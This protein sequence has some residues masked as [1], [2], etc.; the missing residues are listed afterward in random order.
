MIKSIQYF[1]EADQSH[2]LVALD[3]K[4]AFQNVSRRSM[5]HSLRQHDHDLATVFS[6]WYT[7]STTHRMHYDGSYAHIDQGCPLSP[8]GFA[9]AVDPIS[10]YIL[11]QI[12]LTLDNGAKLWAYLDDWYIWIKPQHIPAAKE[13]VANATLTI[14]LELQPT[15]IQIWTASF[16]SP[17]PLD[18]LDKAKPTLKCLGAH[19]RIAGDSE[20]SPVEL[21][22][23]PSM[24]TATMRYRSISAILRDLN[25]AG[26]KMQTVIDLITMYVGAASQHELRTTFVPYEEAANFDNEIEAH[27]SKL[28]GR[29]VASPLFHLPLRMGGLGVGSAVQRHAAAPWTAWQTVIPTLMAATDSTDTDSLLAA[30]PI[31]RGQLLQLQS[32]L[33]QQMN[34]PALLL[35]PL[36]AALRTHGIQ[37]TLVGAIQRHAHKQIMDSY[38]DNPIQRAILISQTAKNTGAHLQQPNREAYEA[39][40]R[41]FQVSMARRLML[42]HPAAAHATDIAPT[43]PNV[44][45]A[46]RVCTCRIDAHQLHCIVCKSGGGV[47]QRHS[48]LARC[49][50]DLV[51]THTGAK[52]QIE[53]TI[54]GLPR[55]LRPRAQPERARMDIVFHLHGQIYYIDTAV[56]TPFSANAGLIA[57][58]S[59]RPSYMAKREEKKKFDRTPRINLVPFILET[60]GRPGLPCTKVHQTPIQR[61]GPPCNSHTRRVG[62]H[63]NHTP[64]LHLQATTP[65]GHHVTA[66]PTVSSPS[67]HH[68]AYTPPPSSP[69]DPRHLSLPQPTCISPR[70]PSPLFSC[71]GHFA[72]QPCSALA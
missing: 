62:C 59:T 47:D 51:T 25:Q 13:L 67:H 64:R 40:D 35:K 44:S 48:A 49:L 55:E 22:G 33:A 7:G 3:L 53:Q 66:L 2:V 11:T 61:H 12:Q 34:T 65:G 5:L 10:R 28:A 41:C 1:A 42:A 68:P 52:V 32:T 15:K 23:R 21:G 50:A 37:K 19:L 26:L 17:I 72:T 63:P 6:R 38:V 70:S 30:T 31:L 4:A 24:N 58:A 16:T 9:A 39:D 27:W 54:P 36:G 71:S 60:T 20:C 45:A 46:K 29:D 43:C 8:C 56:V 14:N 69:L 57:A 18:Y